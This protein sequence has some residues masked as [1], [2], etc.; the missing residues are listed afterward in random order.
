[1]KLSPTAY[2]ILGMVRHEPRSGYEIKALVDKTTRFFWA[3]SYG[4]IYP[5]LKRLS[6]TGLVEGVDSPRGERKR[7]VY[8]ITA[9]GKAVLV[10]WLRTPPETIE[11]REEGLLK[12]FFSGVLSP[13]EAAETLRAMHARRQTIAAQLRAIEPAAQQKSKRGDPYPL[14]VLQAGVEFNE[15]FADWCERM[16]NRL[17]GSAHAERSS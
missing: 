6:E 11:M 13:E 9:E 1:M 2:V 10:D 14:M 12:L 15:W 16:E 4:Q 8:A 7:T 17:L 3:A 5:E